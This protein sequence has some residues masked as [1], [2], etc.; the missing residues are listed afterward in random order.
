VLSPTPLSA[1][2]TATRASVACAVLLAVVTGLRSVVEN[3]IEAVGFLYVV[4][5]SVAAVEFGWH[6]GLTAAAAALAL[7]LFWAELQD[8]SLGLVGYGIRAGM[9]A[10]LGVLVGIQAEQQPEESVSFSS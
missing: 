3:P 6:G 1:T 2:A 8:V 9:F 10:G 4:P 7:T 5:I